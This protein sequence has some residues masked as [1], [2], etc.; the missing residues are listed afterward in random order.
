MTDHIRWGILGTGSIAHKFAIGLSSAPGAELVAVGSRT[1]ASADQFASEFNI[2]RRHA[3]YEALAND[4]DVDAIYIST[5][6]HLHAANSMLCIEAGKA[7]LCEKPF[8]I[9]TREADQVIA[10]ARQ[11]KIFLMEAM[12]TRYLPAIVRLRELIASGVIG[13]VQMLNADF[14][15]RTGF[16]AES[17]LF[18]VSMGGGGLLDVGIYPLSLAFMLFGSPDHIA[19]TAHLGETSVDE[20]AAWVFGYKSGQIAIMSSAIRTNTPHEAVIM[21]TDG[22]IRVPDWW[23]AQKL[24]VQPAGKSAETIDV[25]MEG[26]GYNYEALEVAHCLK[27]GKLESDVMPLDETRAIMVTMDAIRAQWGL[28]YPMD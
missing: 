20:Q 3:S 27:A 1:Q 28:K 13:T 23:H 4:S 19:S 2:P 6:H 17:R 12:W 9:N 8:A 7:V 5:P 14:G 22:M 10:L 25:P 24:I 18:D 21:G 16:R 26:N 11:K 15:F